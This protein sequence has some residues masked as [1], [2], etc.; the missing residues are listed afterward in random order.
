MKEK[1]NDFRCFLTSLLS[2]GPYD[3]IMSKVAV[4]T[5]KKYEEFINKVQ[6]IHSG[7]G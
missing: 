6:N 7:R 4:L 5:N 2:S 3:K 1:D